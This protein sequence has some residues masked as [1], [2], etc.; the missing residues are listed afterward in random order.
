M[1]LY[2]IWQDLRVVCCPYG[3]I[4]QSIGAAKCENTRLFYEK[5]QPQT[6]HTLLVVM[7]PTSKN[8]ELEAAGVPFCTTWQTKNLLLSAGVTLRDYPTGVSMF[9][10]WG[11]NR[12]MPLVWNFW[13]YRDFLYDATRHRAYC[14]DALFRVLHET[15]ARRVVVLGRRFLPAVRSALGAAW[16]VVPAPH[17][18]GLNRSLNGKDWGTEMDRVLREA[19]ARDAH[20]ERM[21]AGALN[22][23]DV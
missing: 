20:A 12:R 8:G 19:N 6:S 5:L 17:P 3:S 11:C 16:D 13:P 9:W 22:P 1:S 10:S 14:Q 23:E 15:G 4:S 7:C 2:E 21:E 18:S